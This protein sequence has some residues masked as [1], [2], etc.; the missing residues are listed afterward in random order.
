[1]GETQTAIADIRQLVYGLRPPAL[2]ELGLVGAIREQAEYLAASTGLAIV[3]ENDALPSLPPAVEV[4]AYRIAI[5]AVTNATRHAGASRCTITLR[6]DGRL[7]LEVADDGG[8]LPAAARAGVGLRSMRE[9]ATE[10][11]GSFEL[12]TEPQRGTRI[13]VSLPV[14][15]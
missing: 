1:V 10:L 3:V 11:S 8:G 12:D 15:T 6:L 4:A 7:K 2:D 14:A 9:R 13:R 5:E